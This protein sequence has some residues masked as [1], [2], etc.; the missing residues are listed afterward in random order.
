[1]KVVFVDSVWLY[2]GAAAWHFITVPKKHSTAIRNAHRSHARAWGSLPVEVSIGKTT[3][4]TSVF[5]DKKSGCYVLPIKA[6][7]RSK[8]K[9]T[10]KSRIRVSLRIKT[11]QA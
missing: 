2:P 7:V 3:W 9:I 5:P 11:P 8:E 4:S 6:S 1:M 10:E